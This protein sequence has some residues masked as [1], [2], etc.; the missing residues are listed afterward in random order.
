M[1]PAKHQRAR[2]LSSATRIMVP[3]SEP[4]SG[5]RTK[6]LSSQLPTAWGCDMAC[7]AQQFTCCMLRV[8]VRC[9]QDVRRSHTPTPAPHSPSPA[10]RSTVPA[11]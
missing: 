10:R 6:E 1:S 8:S 7:S 4:A 5:W 11:R 3:E 2:T 9:N